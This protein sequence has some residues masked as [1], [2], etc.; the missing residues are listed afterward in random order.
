MSRSH[1][2]IAG[3]WWAVAA[4]LMAVACG[5]GA[6]QTP[7][8][9][10][11]PTSSSSSGHG[12][13]NLFFLH[14]SVGD[15][16]VMQGDMRGRIAAYNAAHG[17]TFQFWD[18]GYN[19][20]GLR[21]PTGNPTG[22]NY[23]IP[24]DNTDVEGLFLLWTSGEQRYV[25]CRQRI[26][27]N[28][29]VIAFKSCFPNSAI[30]D[31]DRLAQYKSWYTAIREALDQHPDHAFVVMPPPPLHRLATDAT[32]AGNAR[33]FATWLCSSEYT[34][35]HPNVACFNLFDHLAAPD[36]G[37]SQANRLRWEYEGDHDSDDSHPNEAANQTVGPQLADFICDFAAR[38]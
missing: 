29:Q 18:H 17:T 4:G 9:A 10:P 38:Y 7:E 2:R 6:T 19:A 13:T 36:D 35:G 23:D 30:G 21:D 34:A 20:D 8:T 26:L 16:L 37:S 24:D 28:H 1:A 22:R 11:T 5:G 14:H 32:E 25:D 27:A 33:A 12:L 3:W 31:A 15:G